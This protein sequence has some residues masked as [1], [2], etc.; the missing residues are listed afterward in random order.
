[1]HNPQVVVLFVDPIN[2]E[3]QTERVNHLSQIKLTDLTSIKLQPY[4]ESLTES[5]RIC[6]R[7]LGFCS[8][9]WL[10]VNTHFLKIVAEVFVDG[11]SK[12]LQF[13]FNVF[14]PFVVFSSFLGKHVDLY[15]VLISGKKVQAFKQ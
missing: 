7:I 5:K 9:E 1:M 8:C 3:L 14:A 2:V 10:R 11:V 15:K 12:F 6:A 4:E 13:S